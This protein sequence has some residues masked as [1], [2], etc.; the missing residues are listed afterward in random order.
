MKTKTIFR[1]AIVVCILTMAY[2]IFNK[3][4]SV[5]YNSQKI[6]QNGQY[7]P[8]YGYT[9]VAMISNDVSSTNRTIF[10]YI[11]LIS[12]LFTTTCSHLSHDN[13]LNLSMWESNDTT[14]QTMGRCNR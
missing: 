12:Q 3:I 11:Q 5:P 8:F 1:I 10:A 4:R 7:Q 9:I 2:Y 13:L 6:N 14:N